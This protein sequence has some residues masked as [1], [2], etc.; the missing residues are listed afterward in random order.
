[1]TKQQ[2]KRTARRSQSAASSTEHLSESA[3]LGA[4]ILAE[5]NDLR[6]SVERI[7][8]G[9]LTD[10][11]ATRA[12][13]LFRNSLTVAGDPNRDPRIAIARASEDPSERSESR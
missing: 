7:L 10:E 4:D 1:V 9:G 11:T 13:T 8:Y 6:P 2:P 3:R 5:R 12:L